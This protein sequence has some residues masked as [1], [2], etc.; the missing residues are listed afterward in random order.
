[1]GLLSNFKQSYVTLDESTAQH[2]AQPADAFYPVE[3]HPPATTDLPVTLERFVKGITEY[4]TKLFSIKNTSPTVAYEF[5]RVTPSRLRI[6]FTVP[7]ARL[8]RKLRTHLSEQIPEVGF[9]EGTSTLPVAG[10]DTVGV[11]VLTPRR[12][13]VYPLQTDFETP[14]VNSVVAALHRH[15]MRDTRIVVQLVFKPVAGN[16]IEKRL[17]HR[18]ATRE[19]RTL[20]SDKVGL[21]P[22]TDREATQHERTQA[23]R[24]DAK[25]GSPRFYAAIRFLVIGAGEY[26]ASRV[27]EIAGGF[28]IFADSETGQSFTTK[29]V[30]SFRDAPLLNAV[31][32]VRD[33][34]LD[35]AF[36]L[37][38][39][40]L[41]A[42]VSLPDRDQEN[43]RTTL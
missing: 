43:V 8:E 23:R 3:V 21:L 25:A 32:T 39:Q 16:P 24:I 33:R 11:G 26:T 41:A 29:T 5:H 22:W 37:S 38:T 6:Q 17:W 12:S 28:N 36:Q 10:G 20:R 15:A 35:R 30:R 18:A 34:S 19:S 40:E 9:E 42:L 13:D 2:L 27:K 1:M 7:T 14:P 4:Q 31:Q